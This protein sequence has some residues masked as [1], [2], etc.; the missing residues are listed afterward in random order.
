MMKHWVVLLLA[1][2]VGLGTGLPQ[3]IA[4]HNAGE[5][6]RG[7]YPVYNDD[8]EYY[9][10]RVQEVY[11]GHATIAQP[12]LKEGK[13]GHP[14]Q[15]WMP[16]ALVGFVGMSLNLTVQEVFILFDFIAPAGIFL[17]LYL[18]SYAVLRE[19]VPALAF[20]ILMGCVFFFTTFSRPI[21]PQITIIPLLFLVY[22]LFVALQQENK[23]WLLASLVSFGLL[24][25][26][27]T[28]YWTYGVVFLALLSAGLFFR[29]D[30]RY[31]NVLLVFVG[32]VLIGIPYFIQ[33]KNIFTLPEYQ[34]TVTRLGMIYTHFPSG[35]SIVILAGVYV[36]LAIILFYKQRLNIDFK[37]LYVSSLVLATPIVTNQHLITGQNLEFPS[38]Y[39][40]PGIAFAFLGFFFLWHSLSG[41]AMWSRY[42]ERI[43]AGVLGFVISISMYNVP[44]IFEQ[45][46]LSYEQIELQKYGPVLEWI[47]HSGEEG[48]VYF[49]NQP[50]GVLIPAYTAQNVLYVREANLHFMSNREVMER[51]IASQYFST[52]FSTSTVLEN[53]RLIFGTYYINDYQHFLQNQKITRHF[54][55]FEQ[56]KER[57]PH[58]KVPMI[59]E[60]WE[61]QQLVPFKEI[62]KKYSIDYLVWDSIS[63]PEWKLNQRDIDLDKRYEYMGVIVYAVSSGDN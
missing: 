25:H 20:G 19:R 55:F 48:K 45:S 38:H 43:N 31:R 2:V 30:Y 9:Q 46:Q 63:N 24:F 28:Y 8:E 50:L 3:L 60:L 4:I 5:E 13:D 58:E 23:R 49:V 35:L 15:F 16:D 56:K 34:E 11:D 42:R 22:A 59:I 62:A 40:I 10:A 32:G 57:F 37:T 47:R 36:V 44:T 27:Y 6:W 18:I 41:G 39:R 61:K 21:S 12:Y 54:D 52:D 33:L 7:V 14:L 1:V 51:F 26:A 53:E 29:R 17:L